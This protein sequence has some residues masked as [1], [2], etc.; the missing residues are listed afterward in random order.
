M[1]WPEY[2]KYFVEIGRSIEKEEKER[3]KAEANKKKDEYACDEIIC[4]HV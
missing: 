4:E 2:F 1:T 3:A